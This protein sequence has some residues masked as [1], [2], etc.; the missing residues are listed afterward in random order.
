MPTICFAVKSGTLI[1]SAT[2]MVAV[3]MAHPGQAQGTRTMD[4]LGSIEGTADGSERGWLTIS[5][6]IEGKTMSSAAWRPHSMANVM[7]SAFAGMSEAQQDAMRE[8]M[9]QMAEMMGE[10][11]GTNPMAQMFGGGGEE[12]VELRIMGVD[13]DAEQILRQ[14]SLTLELPP[15]PADTAD[16]M[17]SGP[18]EAEIFYHKNFGE[19][20]GY[21]VSSHDVG[22][23]ATVAFDRLEIVAGGG[24]AAGTFEGSLCPIRSLMGSNPTLEGCIL[25]AGRFETEL[26]EEEADSAGSAAAN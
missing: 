19:Q 14:G 16:Q 25:V 15:F 17:L 12:Y 18:N 4:V 10:G 5:G 6:E 9:E 23:A 26:G 8:R 7:E 2:V 21:F 20:R 1:R 11:A 3:M 24:F 13:P 22:T